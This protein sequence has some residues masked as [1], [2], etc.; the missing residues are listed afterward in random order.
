MVNNDSSVI[1]SEEIKQAHQENQ[2]KHWDKFYQHNKDN[3]FKN[4]NYLSAEFSELN[5]GTIKLPNNAKPV[6]LAAGCGVGNEIFPVLRANPEKSFIGIDC[7]ANAINILKTHPDY[8]ETRIKALVCDMIKD[9]ITDV[10]KTESV[11]LVLLIFVLSAIPPDK[12]LDVL[13]KLYS[14][15]KPGGMVLLK[16]YGL[17]DLTQ[18]RFERRKDSK[19]G[20]NHYVRGDGTFTYY[21]S[22]EQVEKLFK[23]AGFTTTELNKFDTRLIFNRKRKLKMYRVWIRSKFRKPNKE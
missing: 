21:F 10:I 8:D 15:I 4:R 22:L 18:V 2:A 16:D 6:V 9:E 20:S 11:D 1:I 5:E 3:F 12:M 13:K 17:Y 14:V 23:E 7:S 19:L